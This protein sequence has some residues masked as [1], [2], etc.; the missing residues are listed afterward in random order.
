MSRIDDLLAAL[1]PDGV[2]F[3][4][5]GEVIHPT[6]NIKWSNISDEEFKYI[7]LT[8]VDRITHAIVNIQTISSA[9]AP[10]RAQQI[11]RTGD[12]IFGTTRPMLRRYTVVPSEYDGGICSTGYCVLRPNGNVVLSN[13]I[14]H[15]LGTEEFYT[16]VEANERGASYPAISDSAVKAFRIPIPP[17]EVQRAIVTVLDAFTEL[18]A[19]LKA[20]LE[21][22][23]QQYQHYRDALLSFNEHTIGTNKQAAN[24]RWVSLMSVTEYSNTRIEASELDCNN[25]I[26]V[27]NL[28]QNCMGRTSSSYFP[29][30]GKFTCYERD[31]ILLGNIRPYLKKIWHADRR[32]GT[33]GDVLVV[34]IREKEKENIYARYLYQVLANNRFFNYVMQTSKGA[35]MPRG[36]KSMIMKYEIPV[37]P[38][39]EQARIVGI[40]DR[41][42]AL[43]NDLSSGLPAEIAARRQQYEFY[44][45]RLL[46]FRELRREN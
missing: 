15:L 37:P 5:I 20:E 7:D 39:D 29:K 30:M 33:N 35:K 36:S 42:D 11:V 25:Y 19:E 10:D 28:L 22:R 6:T 44:R 34:R 45:D 2:E 17:L 8:S 26:G 4:A 18:E 43:V 1:C 46:T 40:L 32:G 41:F 13:F 38:L 12:V 21:A 24:V 27:D 3:K 23:R 9:N 31:D 14:F 16:Y